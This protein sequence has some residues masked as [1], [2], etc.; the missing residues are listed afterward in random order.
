MMTMKDLSFF[1]R[2]I[3]PTLETVAKVA[4]V[5]KSKSYNLF[6]PTA[7]RIGRTKLS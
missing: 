1:S 6:L 7:V 3:F 2:L 5:L 4:D